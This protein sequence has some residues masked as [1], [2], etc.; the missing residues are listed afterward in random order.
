LTVRVEEQ[1]G[2]LFIKI[3]E[4]PRTLLLPCGKGKFWLAPLRTAVTADKDSESRVVAL[5]LSIYGQTV[6]ANRVTPLPLDRRQL[7]AYSGQ[8]HSRELATVYELR[9]FE[10]G[11]LMSHSRHE[12]V[13]LVPTD[14]DVFE[15]LKRVG[16][17]EFQRDENGVIGFSLTGSRVR[18]LHFFKV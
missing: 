11:L 3:G 5:E 18:N 14:I 4:Q 13:M 12:D 16:M 8:Y 10:G 17:M 15:G 1:W 2:Q 7:E 9:P 6:R